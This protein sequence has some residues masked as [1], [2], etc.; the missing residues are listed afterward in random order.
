MKTLKNMYIKDISEVAKTVKIFPKKEY[1]NIMRSVRYQTIM[2]IKKSLSLPEI[3][4]NP[5]DVSLP[6]LKNIKNYIL[7]DKYVNSVLVNKK[8]VSKV[9]LD[10]YIQYDKIKFK[11]YENDDIYFALNT[12][13][14]MWFDKKGNVYDVV[15]TG[16][17]IIEDLDIESFALPNQYDCYHNVN[18]IL[19][20]NYNTLY[21]L[22]EKY[23]N[24]IFNLSTIYPTVDAFNLACGFIFGTQIKYKDVQIN[25]T[26]GP[27]CEI[28]S[29]LEEP[30]EDYTIMYPE[31]EMH[32]EDIRARLKELISKR[33]F[34]NKIKKN[35]EY[36]F[37]FSNNAM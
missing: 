37:V 3:T 18:C 7:E 6:T 23:I 16:N 28:I 9:Y 22:D 26:E 12:H 8:Y 34:I 19:K 4:T 24:L 10:L 5:V 11:I 21:L 32:E 29:I 27:K 36:L 25:I 1:L 17:Q 15:T 30:S 35:E 14:K 31:P 13:V 20:N 2:P 33:L